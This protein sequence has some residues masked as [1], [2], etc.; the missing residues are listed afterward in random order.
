M[1]RGSSNVFINAFR[2]LPQH[3]SASHCHHQGV[4]VSS[5]ATQAVCIGGCIWITARREWSVVERCN[6]VCTVGS[7]PQELNP[8]Y[9]P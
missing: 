7:V 4:V 5:E 1:R 6:E 3:V 2:D 8:L 9:T